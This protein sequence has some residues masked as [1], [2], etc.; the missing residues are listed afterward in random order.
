MGLAADSIQDTTE[1]V[2]REVPDN[3]LREIPDIRVA[4]LWSSLIPTTRQITGC[5]A[6][7]EMQEDTR[8]EATAE[9]VADAVLTTSDGWR[10]S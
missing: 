9:R 8:I 1:P 6:G 5:S 2:R 4:H 7:Q 3:G 10:R